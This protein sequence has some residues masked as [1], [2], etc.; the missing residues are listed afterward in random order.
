MVDQKCEKIAFLQMSWKCE[1]F[2]TLTIDKLIFLYFYGN[3]FVSFS[4]LKSDVLNKLDW[5]LHSIHIYAITEPLTFI[6]FQK[7]P[8]AHRPNM[9]G[10]RYHGNGWREV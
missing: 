8:A 2:N 3:V 9:G 5:I 6:I 10:F 7:F 1:N 4:N